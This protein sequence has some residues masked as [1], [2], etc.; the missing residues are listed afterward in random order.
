MTTSATLFDSNASLSINQTMSFDS[1]P[2]L[3]SIAL[4]WSLKI[5]L[6]ATTGRTF[7]GGQ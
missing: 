7:K 6:A 4:L 2:D 3:F 5:A 1:V